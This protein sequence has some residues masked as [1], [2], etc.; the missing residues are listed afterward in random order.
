MCESLGHTANKHARVDSPCALK[1]AI[2]AHV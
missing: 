2:H 1:M